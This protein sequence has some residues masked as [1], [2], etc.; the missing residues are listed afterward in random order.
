MI[1]YDK[2]IVKAEGG[3][4]VLDQKIPLITIYRLASYSRYLSDL[5]ANHIKHISSRDIAVGVGS[6][7]AKVRK[8]LSYFGDFGKRGVGYEVEELNA[9][10][11]RILGINRCWKT[12]LIGAGNLGSALASYAG[13]RNRGYEISAIFDR[14]EG[15]IGT[16]VNGCEVCPVE[17][18]VTFVQENEIELAVITV[19]ADAAQEV[20]HRLSTTNIKGILNFAP[21]KLELP[22]HIVVRNLELTVELEVISFIVNHGM[23]LEEDV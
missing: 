11:K 1:L 8:D 18:L 7:P 2:R 19:P 13:F 6:T 12:V 14:D 4:T 21:I 16:K 22:E 23:Q 3:T 5:E 9:A 20:A 17:A 10:I 15:K